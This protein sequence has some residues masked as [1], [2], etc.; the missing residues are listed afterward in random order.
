M[1]ARA[2]RLV[3]HVAID[4][5]IA[6]LLA[7]L[8]STVAL[9]QS[10]TP[11]D[12]AIRA[13]LRLRVDSGTSKGI[14]VGIFEK[15]TRRFI[16]YGSAGPDRRALDEHTVFEVGSISKTVTA[17]L[18]ADAVTRGEVQLD[19]PVAELL[20]TGTVVPSRDG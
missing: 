3:V 1:R 4:W 11:S 13:I 19:E 14:V 8:V 10:S 6:A 18:L 2:S 20:P 7:T 9:A 17:L 15:G 5:I 12:S 16:S